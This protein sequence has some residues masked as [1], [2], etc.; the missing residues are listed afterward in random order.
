[1]ER[2]WWRHLLSHPQ[3]SIHRLLTPHP[4]CSSTTT[5][6]TTATTTTTSANTSASTSP[7][8]PS[9]PP[10]PWRSSSPTAA[11][12]SSAFLSSSS[13]VVIV[14]PSCSSPSPARSGRV[15]GASR[16]RRDLSLHAD[17]RRHGGASPLI[18]AGQ[19][20]VACCDQAIKRSSQRGHPTLQRSRRV[21]CC[22]WNWDKWGTRSLVLANTMPLWR[23]TEAV[24]QTAELQHGSTNTTSKQF[25]ADRLPSMAMMVRR[26]GP[27]R[28]VMNH[29]SQFGGCSGMRATL[30][31]ES[32]AGASISS[33]VD[34]ATRRVAPS[35]SN[36]TN[37]RAFSAAAVGARGFTNT[38]HRRGC[39]APLR[40][41]DS[42]G[43]RRSTGSSGFVNNRA[44]SARLNLNLN[45]NPAIA[46]K[47]GLYGARGGASSPCTT[48]SRGW[49]QSGGGESRVVFLQAASLRTTSF[50]SGPAAAAGDGKTPPP[51]TSSSRTAGASSSSPGSSS[52]SGDG[53][54]ADGT[55]PGSPLQ[56]GSA[57]KVDPSAVKS[58]ASIGDERTT[59]KGGNPSCRAGDGSFMQMRNRMRHARFDASEDAKDWMRDKRDDM[60]TMKEVSSVHFGSVRKVQSGF[61]VLRV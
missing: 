14:A 9:T 51:E 40:R 26:L 55:R 12:A 52:S 47:A 34:V 18:E 19:V 46:T 16:R 58:A 6:P 28:Y 60:N 59:V 42:G 45:P 25:V 44:P 37:R 1:M 7:A 15:T 39:S 56:P 11:S 36:S 13:A 27:V 31:P 23:R 3:L 29:P 50:V 20:C 4:G 57:E 53:A 54:T 43:I 5:A 38:I 21:L 2:L 8:S 24:N 32:M 35:S 30:V 49:Q 17:R 41:R 22:S 61:I 10:S 48:S 33:P